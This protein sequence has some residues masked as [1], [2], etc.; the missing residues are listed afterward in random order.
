V[1]ITTTGGLY[2]YDINDIVRVEG[3]YNE[4][5]VITFQ[6]K[7]RGMTSLT[8]EKV[9][10]TQVIEAVTSAAAEAGVELAHFRALADVDAARYVF[11]VEPKGSL[12]ESR[13]AGCS[14]RSSRSS[15]RS[16]SSTPA[17][18]R[19]SGSKPRSCT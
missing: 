2:R 4:A 14:S 16:T 11:Q 13:R 15:R 6:R 18:A 3:F 9:S 12:P 19:A 17:S 1:F 8:G 7:G 5:P 10:D